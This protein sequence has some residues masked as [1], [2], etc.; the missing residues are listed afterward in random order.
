MA[1]SYR[2][3]PPVSRGVL[4]F[5]ADEERQCALSIRPFADGHYGV[6]LLGFGGEAEVEGYDLIDVL[7]QIRLK[8]EETG[9]FIAIQGSRVNAWAPS[10]LRDMNQ[11]RRVAILE[12]GKKVVSREAVDTLAPAD[13]ADI[14]TVAAQREFYDRWKESF[15]SSGG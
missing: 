12:M 4:V 5:S 7:R 3:H 1:A 8:L 13:R 9:H 11:G 2:V 15:R 6:T 14:A 10:I